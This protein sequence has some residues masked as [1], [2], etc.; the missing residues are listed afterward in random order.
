[1]DKLNFNIFDLFFK[2]FGGWGIVLL[3]II[4]VLIIYMF[5]KRKS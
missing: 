3:I 4:I 2:H 1:M 5:A